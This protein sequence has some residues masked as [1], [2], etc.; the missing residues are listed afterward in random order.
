MRDDWR[1]LPLCAQQ[2][3]LLVSREYLRSRNVHIGPGTVP[4]VLRLRGPLDYAVV[5]NVLHEIISR[6]P[7]LRATF[8]PVGTERRDRTAEVESFASSGV[9]RPGLY[10]QTVLPSA[11]AVL[12]IL[13]FSNLSPAEKEQ[14]IQ[15]IIQQEAAVEFDYANPPLLRS[16]LI[17]SALDEHFLI[18]IID[19]LVSD[20]WSMRQVRLQIVQ[21]YSQF[22]RGQPRA[23]P[24]SQ[25]SYPHYAVLQWEL[26]R[27]GGFR[28]SLEHWL[29]EWSDFAPSRIG[30]GHLPFA[31][32]PPEA[33]TFTFRSESLSVGAGLV[34]AVKRFARQARVTLYVLF[35]CFYCK[36]LSRYTQ[37]AKVAI[38]SH[39]ANRMR[40]EIFDSVGWFSTTHLI[41]V[42]TDLAFG[43][44]LM[45]IRRS[46][47][48]ASEHQ[49]L[50]VALVWRAMGVYPRH[51]DAR[52][53]LD[54]NVA[55]DLT[56][57]RPANESE[58][59]IEHLPHLTP[60]FGRFSNLGLYIRDFREDLTL[61][62][63][64]DTQR[65]PESDVRL[66]LEEV[67]GEAVRL[68]KCSQ[69][70]GSDS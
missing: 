11:D 20:A 66:L 69:L 48:K 23:A 29:Q 64:Y 24:Q 27:T 12:R 54:L 46:V 16:T 10:L 49:E 58:L 38:W 14:G 15:R 26:S 61:T 33:P 6:H 25:M 37:R 34:Q 47:L 2:E 40:P 32:P 59:T 3:H 8:Y 30:F 36:V 51:P 1:D 4:S 17:R 31:L 52:L 28:R 53:L 62:M 50:P 56:N 44:T 57:A 19:H 55:E 60:S 67:V 41:G 18:L 45:N 68:M 65:F 39:F 21:L 63:Q 42:D 43:D 35:L 13:D 5:K 7:A 9:F 70:N 22:L